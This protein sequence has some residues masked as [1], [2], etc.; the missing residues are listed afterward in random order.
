MSEKAAPTD[1]FTFEMGRLPCSRL[2]VNHN[3][4]VNTKNNRLPAKILP[5]TRMPAWSFWFPPRQLTLLACYATRVLAQ[6][7]G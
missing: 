5:W 7:L 4:M 1:I 2:L 6:C 3:G